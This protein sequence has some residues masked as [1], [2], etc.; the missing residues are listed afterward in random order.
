[1]VWMESVNDFT[2]FIKESLPPDHELQ[3]H[4]LFPGIKWDKR[5]IFIVDDD[6]T[7]EYH[8]MDFEKS[9]RWKKTKYKV[10]AITVLRTRKDVAA[11]IEQDHYTEMAL[12]ND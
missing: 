9:K 4:D 8:H 5:P 2:A 6:T 3:G 7:G 11:I 12:H 1:M 10:P